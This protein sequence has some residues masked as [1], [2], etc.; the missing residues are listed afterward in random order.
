MEKADVGN[1]KRWKGGKIYQT[2][3]KQE[4]KKKMGGER[5]EVENGEK[6]RKKKRKRKRKRKEWKDRER[7]R[8]KARN[9]MGVE[10]HR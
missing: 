8:E 2:V 6:N 4:G 10:K 9:G 3:K 1:W 7:G 5:A